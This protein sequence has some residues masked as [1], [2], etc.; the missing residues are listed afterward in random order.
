[1]RYGG[2]RE[3]G[4][5]VGSGVVEG[6]CRTFGL[7]PRRSGTGRAER[8]ANAM[9]APRGRAM[10]LR[11]PDFLEWRANQAMAAWATNLGYT[12]QWS[13]TATPVASAITSPRPAPTRK[14]LRRPVQATC[15]QA[16]RPRTRTPVPSMCL[17]EAEATASRTRGAGPRRLRQR[18]RPC[19]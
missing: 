8:G 14:W 12:R 11:L 6:G 7:R 2:F 13:C 17:P 10:S 15:S 16:R 19:S 18:G 3:R 4:I 1:M 5:Q 9:L